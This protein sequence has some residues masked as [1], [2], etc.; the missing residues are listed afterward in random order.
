M[1]ENINEQSKKING[2]NCTFRVWKICT[3][4]SPVAGGTVATA[5]QAT[6][7]VILKTLIDDINAL[8]YWV[9]QLK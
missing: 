5:L 4:K 1:E 9:A 7:L 8:L 3:Q 6:Q 2:T